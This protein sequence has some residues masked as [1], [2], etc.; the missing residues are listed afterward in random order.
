VAH[1][2][3]SVQRKRVVSAGGVVYRRGAHG[4]EIVL[5]GRSQEGLWALPKGTPE[6]GESLE[7]AALREVHEETGLDVEI[8]GRV[9]SIR[10]EFTGADGT[11]YDKRVD[12]YLMRPVGGSTAQHDG[13]FDD[14]RWFPAEEA[15][16]F[17]TYPN[18]RDVVRKALA[19]I[20]EREGA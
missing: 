6:A 14:V 3:S 19:L 2:K 1:A 10:Y 8:E 13:E 7:Q 16:R 4:P 5:C 9:G 11:V 17:M 15:L 18:E 12:H 20:E